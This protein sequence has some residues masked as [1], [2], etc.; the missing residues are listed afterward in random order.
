MM[1]LSIASHVICNLAIW[2]PKRR[3]QRLLL[4]E[5]AGKRRHR[6]QVHVRKLSELLT[7]EKLVRTVVRKT[8]RKRVLY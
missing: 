6:K 5:M 2:A 4:A 3:E 8:V 1:A 7:E